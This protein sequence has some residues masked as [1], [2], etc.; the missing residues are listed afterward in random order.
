MHRA[1]PR[2][3]YRGLAQGKVLGHRPSR[4]RARLTNGKRRAL[5][6]RQAPVL[7]WGAH[8]RNLVIAEGPDAGW[9]QHEAERIEPKPQ[10][11]A[12]ASMAR[13][14]GDTLV[15]RLHDCSI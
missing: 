12:D 8:L 6:L 7:F 13:V 1:A 11:A 10:T 4:A 5:T 2:V 15:G 3:A 9:Y 14:T